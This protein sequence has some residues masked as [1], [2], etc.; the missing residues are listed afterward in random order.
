MYYDTK[1]FVYCILIIVMYVIQLKEEAYKKFDYYI[2]H[3]DATQRLVLDNMTSD[4]PDVVSYIRTWEEKIG[5]MA[6]LVEIPTKVNAKTVWRNN[7]WKDQPGSAAIM[8]RV[9]YR[10][11]KFILI[12]NGKLRGRPSWWSSWTLAEGM[13]WN[14]EQRKW[15]SAHREGGGWYLDLPNGSLPEEETQLFQDCNARV[16]E[17]RS[18]GINVGE[19]PTFETEQPS[20]SSKQPSQS[21]K[22]HI[23]LRKKR[24]I[25]DTK[26]DE[27]DIVPNPKSPS[28]RV[29]SRSQI[30][31]VP[32]PGKNLDFIPKVGLVKG[33]WYDCH[34]FYEK[35]KKTSPDFKKL[36][37]WM[38]D[39]S[40]GKINN[41]NGI[42]TKA[43][44][45]LIII[46]IPD[47]MP[48]HGIDEGRT[49]PSWMQLKT[50][51]WWETLFDFLE[52]ILSDNGCT[53]IMCNAKMP[54]LQEKIVS[55]ALGTRDRPKHFCLREH[56]KTFTIVNCLPQNAPNGVQT[57]L[58]NILLLKKP[59]SSFALS[60]AA[61]YIDPFV[62]I[63]QL[64][65]LFNQ[66]TNTNMC[67]KQCGQPWRGAK[68]KSPLVMQQLIEACSPLHGRI[69]DLSVGTGASFH[70]AKESER[71]IFGFEADEEIHM[72]LLDALLHSLNVEA[73]NVFQAP[74]EPSS[75]I[76]PNFE[77]VAPKQGRKFVAIDVSDSE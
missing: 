75:S 52:S 35:H 7:I 9:I 3:D 55:Y 12:A 72:G 17:Q 8:C 26:N 1:L 53:L 63:K 62:D 74:S 77:D 44:V 37:S 4:V 41:V 34:V 51:E 57:A 54:R 76:G 11:I 56:V 66:I 10:Y 50:D 32:K 45:D 58:S 2:N 13:L 27:E 22:P 64:D 40:L 28:G 71:H 68:E 15:P 49:I 70:A 18:V 43:C 31:T 60:D 39:V 25:I 65:V 21:S 59:S 48:I 5:N 42:V 19:M 30:A 24:K 47:G 61:S 67:L 33:D 29:S 36:M 73:S 16:E 14:I 38:K 6:F 23:Q 69:L 20:E 46:D